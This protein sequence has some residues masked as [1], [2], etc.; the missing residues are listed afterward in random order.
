MDTFDEYGTC[1]VCESEMQTCGIIQLGY[2][3]KSESGW[4]CLQCGLAMEGAIAI[5]CGACIDK[6]EGNVEDQIKYL[7]NGKK[8]RLPV[9][10]AEERIPHE[11]DLSFHPEYTEGQHEN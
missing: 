7:M 11:H 1:C 8:G 2:K 9:P 3:I 5:V 6:Y 4:G 10:P